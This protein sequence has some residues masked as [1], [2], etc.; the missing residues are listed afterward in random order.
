M[1]PDRNNMLSSTQ[2]RM[3][4]PWPYLG[5]SDYMS[6]FGR[7]NALVTAK[8]SSARKRLRNLLTRL[9]YNPTSAV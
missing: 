2:P 4:V 7:E 8:L 6:R 5:T 9:D 3:C 1:P